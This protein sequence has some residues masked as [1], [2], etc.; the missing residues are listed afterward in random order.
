MLIPKKP[1]T[2]LPMAYEIWTY[3]IYMY[4]THNLKIA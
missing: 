3:K 2:D 4:A 1:G